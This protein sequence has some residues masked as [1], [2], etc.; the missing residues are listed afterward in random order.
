M[1]RAR[2]FQPLP[3]FIRFGQPIVTWLAFASVLFG[4]SSLQAANTNQVLKAG[5]GKAAIELPKELFPFKAEQFT[6]EHD[7][8]QTKVVLLDNGANRIALVVID[9]TS[10]S[11]DVIDL[12]RQ[13]INKTAGV[14]PNNTL[15]S[16][17]HTFS[18][19]HVPPAQQTE[20]A[21]ERELM[22]AAVRN[23]V[24]K[25]TNDAVRNLQ[26]A[27]IGFG[28][29][30]SYVNI[31]RD[32]ESKDGW[33]LGANEHGA[34]DKSVGII[35]IDNPNGEPMAVLMNYAVQ[36]STMNESIGPDGGKVIT[37][38][39]AGAATRYVEQQY[40]KDVVS[41]FLVGA[42]GD[43][44]PVYVANRYTLDKNRNAGRTDIGNAGLLLVDLMGERLGSESV[45]VSE[46]IHTVPM[47][48]PLRIVEG[49]VMLPEL[50]SSP[51]PAA[52]HAT[53]QYNY[54]EKGKSAM[55]YWILQIGDIVCVGVQVELSAATGMA[56]KAKSPFKN[57][58]VMNMVNGAA[59]YLPDAESFDKIT[60]EAEGARYAKGS[61]EVFT[62]RVVE[63]LKR[64]QAETPAK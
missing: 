18:S 22:S 9:A 14:L 1:A 5:A 61:A 12:S 63:D 3:C 27:R 33:W 34:S 8:L 37:A 57:T 51:N 58:I 40:G 39:L 26:P 42:A 4:T 7:K 54:V 56:I 29:G 25:A 43:Q 47:S 28:V 17:S 32:L 19:P 52:R 64:L 13:I 55:P 62:T 21:H 36:S 24:Q 45:R 2:A 50:E 30:T 16:A 48:T 23:A 41:L 11:T 35:R 10:L 53:H 44:S 46:A 20:R 49:S 15:V 60:Y 59:K 38:D 6:T 31:S